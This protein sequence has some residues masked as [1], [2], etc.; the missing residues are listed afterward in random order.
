MTLTKHP[1]DAIR[2][3]HERHALDQRNG[4]DANA[5][6]SPR[7][8]EWTLTASRII[9]GSVQNV[10]VEFARRSPPSPLHFLSVPAR[11]VHGRAIPSIYEV[12]AKGETTAVANLVFNC[13]LDAG[14]VRVTSTVPCETLPC[15]LALGNVT[16]QWARRVAEDVLIAALL[17][18]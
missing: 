7:L 12:R 16:E 17:K 2:L 11:I 18:C 6:H 5:V 15:E 1:D 3:Y 8:K 13:D 10:S 9:A 14:A 4:R